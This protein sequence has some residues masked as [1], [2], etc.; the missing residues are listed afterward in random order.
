MTWLPVTRDHLL[1]SGWVLDETGLRG[2]DV[3]SPP[4]NSSIFYC[5]TNDT[6]LLYGER[7]RDHVVIHVKTRGRL[8]MALDLLEVQW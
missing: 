7:D 3:F 2:K 8:W 4:D 6:L 1:L 5:L